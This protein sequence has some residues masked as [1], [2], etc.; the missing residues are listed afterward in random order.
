MISLNKN[1]ISEFS[2]I[3]KQLKRLRHVRGRF[4]LQC[5]R[6][7]ASELTVPGERSVKDYQKFVLGRVRR[8]R[9]AG[10]QESNFRR[11]TKNGNSKGHKM[12]IKETKQKP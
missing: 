5:K 11:T 2:K 1:S 10:T 12:K 6:V 7:S 8:S 3:S 9:T 4:F